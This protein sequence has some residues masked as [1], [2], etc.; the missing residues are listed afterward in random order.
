MGLAI[1]MVE[2]HQKFGKTLVEEFTGED[3]QEDEC[4]MELLAVTPICLQIAFSVDNM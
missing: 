4:Q 3:N 1:L 2:P